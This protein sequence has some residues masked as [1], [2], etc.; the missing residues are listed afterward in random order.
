MDIVYILGNGSLASND[1]LRYSLRSLTRHCLDIGKIFVVGENADFLTDVIH[2]PCEDKHKKPWKNTLDKIKLVCEREDL[3]D[4]FLLMN[5]DFF[6]LEDFRIDELPYYAQKGANGGASGPLSFAVHRPIRLN[7]KFYA[8]M[9]IDSSMSTQLSPRS[10]YG[11]FFKC[12][13]T[14]IKDCVVR[15]GLENKSFDDQ[16]EGESWFTID[17]VTMCDIEFRLWIDSIFPDLCPYESYP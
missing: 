2:V 11:N 6:A 15:T 5:D 4:D 3:S 13:P 8:G 17:D 12:P 14:Y 1:E 16:I 9:P 7:K 10:F